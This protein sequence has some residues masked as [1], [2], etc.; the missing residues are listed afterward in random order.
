MAAPHLNL[1]DAL[2]TYQLEI[3]EMK[4]AGHIYNE[5]LS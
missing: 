5:I 3:T 4:R 2:T 1:A